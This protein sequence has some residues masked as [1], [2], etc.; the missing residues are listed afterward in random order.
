MH[1]EL[2]LSFMEAINTEFIPLLVK[3]LPHLSNVKYVLVLISSIDAL[4][5]KLGTRYV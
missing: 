3:D 5:P 2:Q 1:V 4:M